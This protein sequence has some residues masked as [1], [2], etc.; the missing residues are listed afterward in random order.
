MAN[1]NQQYEGV[2][3]SETFSPVVKQPT[4]RVV[5]S[6]AVTHKWPIK[7]LDV[8]N[9]FLHGVIDEHVFMRQPQGY[10]SSDHPTYVCKL[11]KAL[12]G[13]RQ[14][15][16]AWFSVFSSFLL[17]QGFVPSKADASLFI[18]HNEHGITIVLIYVDDI[19]VTGSN[20][21]YISELIKIL[22]HQ[23]CYERFGSTSLFSG[24]RG[25]SGW[26]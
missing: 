14:A 16:R 6:M 26:C 24:H 3:F 15:P 17:L 18:L 1:G 21:A 23:I 10:R 20:S 9:A 7:Q 5:L 2:D 12:Y 22:G 19:I 13:L 4:I 25:S 11:N 8:S